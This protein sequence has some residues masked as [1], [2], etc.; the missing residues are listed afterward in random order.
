MQFCHVDIKLFSGSIKWRAH[1]FKDLPFIKCH[2]SFFYIVGW[3]ASKGL[4]LASY[5][6]FHIKAAAAAVLFWG[7]IVMNLWAMNKV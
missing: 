6:L 4:V 2:N 5:A 7:E 1:F 3:A